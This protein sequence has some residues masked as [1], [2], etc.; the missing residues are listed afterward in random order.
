MFNEYWFTKHQQILLFFLNTPLLRVWFRWF[1]CIEYK[2]PIDVILPNSI[3]WKNKG[4]ITTEFR[5]HNKYAKRLYVGLYPLWWLCHQ[6]DIAFYP[7]FN[8]GFDTLGP[9]QPVAGDNSP[10]DG[11]VYRS[12]VDETFSSIRSGAGNGNN[13][14]DADII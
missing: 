6:W 4:K 12:G 3:S 11:Y 1:L 2:E 9:V 10:I 7:R 5:S 8:L 14:T 13:T